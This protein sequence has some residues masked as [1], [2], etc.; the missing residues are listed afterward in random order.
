MIGRICFLLLVCLANLI[1]GCDLGADSTKTLSGGYFLRNEGGD[2][3]DIL[4]EKP[5]GGEIPSTVIDFDYDKKFIV[6]K[7]KPKIP[8]DP[9][10][11]KDYQYKDGFN[12][13]YFWLIVHEKNLVLGPFSEA[14]FAVIRKE[15]N[16]LDNL[17]F[18]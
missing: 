10:Y 1:Q 4:C 18:K 13:S 3:T 9:L 15:Y 17:M 8:Q 7:Q 16:V 2:I 14:E 11:N 12:T 6:A 5:N